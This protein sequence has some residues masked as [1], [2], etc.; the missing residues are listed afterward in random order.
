MQTH[1]PQDGDVLVSNTSATLEHVI[2]VLPQP[3]HLTC[4]NHNEAVTQGR[5]LAQRLA[6]D[7]WLT[8]DHYH[9]IPI[10]SFRK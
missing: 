1:A 10:G 8:E 7:A 4:A 9:F 2:C 3:P 6:V 5:E